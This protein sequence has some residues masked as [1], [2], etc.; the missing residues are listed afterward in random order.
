MGTSGKHAAGRIECRELQPTIVLADECHACDVLTVCFPHSRIGIPGRAVDEIVLP[1]GLTRTGLGAAV[2]GGAAPVG[3]GT[4]V[5]RPGITGARL[6]L[7]GDIARTPGAPDIINIVV[8]GTQRTDGLFGD[9]PARPD[10]AQQRAGLY[11]AFAAGGFAP[12]A[13]LNHRWRY[14]KCPPVPPR[15]R[16]SVG[17]TR[18]PAPG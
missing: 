2:V 10:I 6:V 9:S 18:C 14:I 12:S 5:A 7:V 17:K 1:K 8:G 11:G 4:G 15:C 3:I 16:R 13:P